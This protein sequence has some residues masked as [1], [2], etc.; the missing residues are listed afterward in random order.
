MGCK[1]PGPRDG[2][3]RGQLGHIQG[4]QGLQ[5]G[6]QA[7]LTRGLARDQDTRQGVSRIGSPPHSCLLTRGPQCWQGWG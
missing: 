3:A 6:H 5:P 2:F 7:L 4:P 1:G